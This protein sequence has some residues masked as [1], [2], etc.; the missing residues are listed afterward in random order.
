[1]R[2]AICGIEIESIDEAIEQGSGFYIEGL[3]L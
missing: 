3:P 2:C 1:M